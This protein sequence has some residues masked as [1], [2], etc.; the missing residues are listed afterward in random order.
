MSTIAILKNH[1]FNNLINVN[2][3]FDEIKLTDVPKT[4]YVC[5][6]TL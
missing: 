2:G 6:S 4:E 5:P 3:G 1:G